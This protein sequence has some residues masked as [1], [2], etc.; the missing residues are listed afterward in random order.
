MRSSVGH[1]PNFYCEQ[2]LSEGISLGDWEQLT[3]R[4]V[5]FPEEF[6]MAY[7]EEY[8]LN[9]AL[10]LEE[11]VY[12]RA[13][14]RY[15]V[16]STLERWAATDNIRTWRSGM[17][18]QIET[19]MVLH[20]GDNFE[21]PRE[22][23]E[24]VESLVVEGME[25]TRKVSDRD[26]GQGYWS[27]CKEDKYSTILTEGEEGSNHLPVDIA[28]VIGIATRMYP[29]LLDLKKA[30]SI[31]AAVQEAVDYNRLEKTIEDA[32]EWGG[33]YE[34]P[35]EYLREDSTLFQKHNGC[36]ESMATERLIELDPGRLSVAR[37]QRSVSGQNPDYGLIHSL[38]AHGMPVFRDPLFR[39]NR[40]NP[41]PVLSKDTITVGRTLR[42]MF[43]EQYREGGQAFLLD[44]GSVDS[45]GIDYHVS[46][47][48]WAPK[49]GK[50][51]GRP[52]TDCSNG[53]PGHRA[54]DGFFPVCQLQQLS[55][56]GCRYSGICRPMIPFVRALYQ[57]YIG[58][59]GPLKL[60]AE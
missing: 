43:I 25:A 36:L 29:G 45:K 9:R 41:V 49:Q 55:S 28:E 53:G 44:K 4:D 31:E 34:I 22:E 17:L 23:G 30:G 21:V 13:K 3:M 20:V 12:R 58:R 8:W 27:S 57:A 48:S 35:A 7:G 15:C 14:L 56:L 52:I 50:A 33:N 19:N 18:E 32:V 46:R 26:G 40:G 37:V 2:R 54:I 1:T 11:E 6:G 10:L 51:Q 42:K 47:M 16:P 38:A 5:T 59:R 60:L 24:I 39:G